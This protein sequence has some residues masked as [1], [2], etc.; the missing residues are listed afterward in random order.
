MTRQD[1]PPEEAAI[2]G[3]A[4]A[5]VGRRD[6]TRAKAAMVL[7]LVFLLGGL[8]GGAIGRFTAMR[9][10]GRM[11]GGPPGEARS[12]FRLE[13]LRRHLDLREDQID[14]VKAILDE[15]DVERERLMGSCGPGLDDLRARTDARVR[16]LL[17]EDQRKQL[18]AFE[19]RRGQRR[20]PRGGHGH[21][22]FGP[23]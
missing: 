23:P 1:A 22:G 19:A 18:D 10:V 14:R 9:E 7:A 8:A 5:P 21:P 20:G 3:P 11:M 15:A 6:G 2:A 13:A 4:R 16:A 12:R 17:D